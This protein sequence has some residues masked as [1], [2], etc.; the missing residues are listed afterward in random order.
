MAMVGDEYKS[1]LKDLELSDVHAQAWEGK[2]KISL[3]PI[4]ANT[5]YCCAFGA[6]NRVFMVEDGVIKFRMGYSHP[7]SITFLSISDDYAKRFRGEAHKELIDKKKVKAIELEKSYIYLLTNNLKAIIEVLIDRSNLEIN[8]DNCE[9][10]LE[11]LNDKN[12]LSKEPSNILLINLVHLYQ[13]IIALNN[14]INTSVYTTYNNHIE[15]DLARRY[16]YEQICEFADL[17]EK[18]K[19][20]YLQALGPILKKNV[21]IALEDILD[22]GVELS[23]V[24]HK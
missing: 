18:K 9:L 11:V 7:Y 5:N 8:V 2:Q 20:E 17:L 1:V 12:P 4:R 24:P 23:D 22:N 3:I 21:P 15:V 14:S 19:N 10:M 16:F 13:G 6:K